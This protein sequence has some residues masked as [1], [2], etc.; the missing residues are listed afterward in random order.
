MTLASS[1]EIPAASALGVLVAVKP[2]PIAAAPIPP[3]A[4]VFRM[5]HLETLPFFLPLLINTSKKLSID[6]KI[7]VQ[8][9]PI[10]SA[11]YSLS[12]FNTFV[13]SLKSL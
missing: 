5:F 2:A 7:Q 1:P 3:I 9:P 13:N 8:H 12:N 10:E 6:C 11:P 4:A